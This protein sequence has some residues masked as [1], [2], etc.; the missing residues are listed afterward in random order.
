MRYK[1]KHNLEAGQSGEIQLI[2][3]NTDE[4]N[5]TKSNNFVKYCINAKILHIYM[6]I[7]DYFLF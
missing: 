4:I 3:D 2:I 1:G 6:V 5:I 7:Y